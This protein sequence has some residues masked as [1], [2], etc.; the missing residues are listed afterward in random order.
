M[1]RRKYK[2]LRGDKWC[3]ESPGVQLVEEG[4]SDGDDG[5]GG[6]FGDGALE[7]VDVPDDHFF[8]YCVDDR[9]EVVTT[10]DHSGQLGL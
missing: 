9:V 6:N 10:T 5:E 2:I 4:V 7:T 8:S 3:N 1:F